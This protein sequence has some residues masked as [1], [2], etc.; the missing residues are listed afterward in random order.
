MPDDANTLTANLARTPTALRKVPD[1]QLPHRR[2]GDHPAAADR[3]LRLGLQAD[4]DG[5][6]RGRRR[7]RD[8]GVLFLPA[9]HGSRG[10]RR[11]GG[12]GPEGPR[13][14][15]RAAGGAQPVAVVRARVASNRPV[16][17]AKRRLQPVLELHRRR[18]Q[19]RHPHRGVGRRHRWIRRID[20]R[21]RQH[22]VRVCPIRCPTRW[23]CSPTR[24]RCPC[25]R[26]PATRR[27]RSGRALVYGAGS[28]GLCA[29]AILRAL[30]PDVA[31]AVVARFDAQAELARR[32]GAAK[33]LAHEPRLAVIEE[34]VAWGGGRLRQPLLGLPMAYPGAHRRRLRHRRQARDVRSRRPGAAVPG[35]AG[36]GRRAR[37]R[38]MGVEP[39]VLQ[40][41]QLGGVECLRHR[42]GRRAAQARHRP[43]P[44]PGRRRPGGPAAHADPH[45]PARAVARRLPGD[46]QPGRERRGQGGLSTSARRARAAWRDSRSSR[47]RSGAACD[48]TSVQS[49]PPHSAV[50]GSRRRGFRPRGGCA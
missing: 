32:F 38:P 9:S 5:L 13:A 10:G 23:R 29:V 21:P 11:R 19:A 28:L 49:N 46:R 48:A 22:A 40:G 12:G 44:R 33:V 2:L 41:D 26:S 20:A 36:E 37:A 42:G 24:F 14:R 7:Q 34:L 15:G 8:V 17:H 3:H 25:T 4:P 35:D 31:V 16:P 6:R 45:L 43:L 50:E 39:A 1:P 30:Y 27:R 47:P 18:H